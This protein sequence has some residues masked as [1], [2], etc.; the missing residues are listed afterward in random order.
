MTFLESP[1]PISVFTYD[2]YG[3]QTKV[4]GCLSLRDLSLRGFQPKKRSIIS[5]KIGVLEIEGTKISCN[6]CA[7]PKRHISVRNRVFRCI[8]REN[9]RSRL[10]STLVN[11]WQGV[12]FPHS[13]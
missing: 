3:A 10:G 13:P 8:L 1:T 2:F 11:G 4:N 12:K 6:G 7:T 9:R 5:P